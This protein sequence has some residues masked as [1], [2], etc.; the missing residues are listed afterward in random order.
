MDHHRTNARPWKI[1]SWNVRGINSQ[2]KWSTIKSKIK[3]VNCDIICLQETKRKVFDEAYLRNFCSS[4]FDC[5]EYI[6]SIGSSGGTIIVGRSP[7][8]IGQVV[9]QNEYAMNVEFVYVYSCASWILSNIY[10]PCSIEGKQ[11]FINWLHNID[12]PENVDWLI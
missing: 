1:L 6:T 10:A 12:M 2:H 9:F 8:F 11:V 3:E 5:F 7:R 4:N